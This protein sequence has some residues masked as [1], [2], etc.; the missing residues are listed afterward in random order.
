M[1]IRLDEQN[2]ESV[3]CEEASSVAA[4]APEASIM[5]AGERNRWSKTEQFHENRGPA[6]MNP[7]LIIHES[8]VP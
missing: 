3:Q 2:I 6:T 5:V 8:R 7:A 4:P 1:K